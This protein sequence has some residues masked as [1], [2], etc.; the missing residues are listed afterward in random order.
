MLDC[1]LQHSCE[2]ILKLTF[3][4]ITLRKLN[5]NT[6][7]PEEKHIDNVTHYK[8]LIYVTKSLKLGV[9]KIF[10]V[11]VK[12]NGAAQAIR[13]LISVGQSSYNGRREASKPVSQ[14]PFA[15]IK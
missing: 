12:S 6:H 13:V 1:L 9:I 3:T 14:H 8:N 2:Y 5:K 15:V 10:Q 4:N 7:K 11:W